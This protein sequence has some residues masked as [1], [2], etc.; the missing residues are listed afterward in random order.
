MKKKVRIKGKLKSYL[1]WPIFL[2]PLLICMNIS[3]FFVNVKAGIL[4]AVYT[5]IYL[6][7]ASVI[8][9]YKRTAVLGDL[10]RYAADYGKVQKQLLRE[11]ALPYGILDVEGHLLWGNDEFLSVISDEKAARKSIKNV[12]PGLETDLLPKTEQ[13]EELHLVIDERYYKVIMRRIILQEGEENAKGLGKELERF[14]DSSCLISIYLHDETDILSGL[15]EIKNQK[16]IAGLLYIDNYEEALDTVDEVRRSLLIALVD[17]KINKYMQSIDAIAKKLE[18]D[19]YIFVFQNRYLEKLREDKFSILEEVR[20]V[21]IGNDM[22][23]TISLGL[24]VNGE[25]YTQAYEYA[26]AAIDLAL[27]RGGDQAVIKEGDRISYYGGKSIQVE[28]NT[29]VKARVKAHALR[30][31]IEAKEEVFIMGHSLGDVDSFGASIGIYRAAKTLGKKAHIV[32]NEVSSSVRPIMDRFLDNPDYEED[33]IISGERAIEKV[34]KN[35]LLVIVDVN[36]PSY[37][38]CRELIDLTNTVVILDHHRRTDE[39]IEHAV[40][41]YIEPYASSACEMVAEILQYIADNLKLKQAEADAMYA[42]IMI[43]TNNFLTKT[44]VRTFEAAAYLRRHG[45]DV[46]RIRKGFRSEMIEY[47]VKAEAIQ[48]TEVYMDCYAITVCAGKGTESPTIL[49]AQVANELLDIQGIKASFVLTEYNDKIYISARS[50]DELNVQVVMEKLGGGGH[51]SVAGA[52]LENCTIEEAKEIVRGTL[53][54][55]NEE[56]EL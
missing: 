46:T 42:G 51:L 27:G 2:T 12:I 28:K 53:R 50:I 17:R 11:M 55:M 4:M 36:R 7:I 14:C 40:L 43:D 26:R 24:G 18:K 3:M 31:L 35:M 48:Q 15:Q 41:S 44:G 5:F 20:S 29:R 32:I 33:M 52:Q 13:D 1:Q 19:K 39:A 49:G 22:A 56:G 30:E 37:T 10:V 47:K 23:V 45:A 9:V 16:L 34:N 38:E 25:T 8:F 21:N 54:K 6:V